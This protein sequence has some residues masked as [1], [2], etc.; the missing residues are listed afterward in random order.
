MAR[1]DRDR[2]PALFT[3]TTSVVSGVILAVLTKA[4]QAGLSAGATVGWSALVSAVVA[5]ACLAG[6]AA[7][8]RTRNRSGTAFLMTS[9][10]TQKYYVSALVQRVHSALDRDDIDLALKVPD[11]DYDAGAQAHHLRRILSKKHSY[12][13]GI[14]IAG[15]VSR[16]REDLTRFCLEFRLP[17]VF[18]DVE[19]FPAESGY[20]NNTAFVG[21]DTGEL[22]ELAGQ[23]LVKHLRGKNRPRVLIIA[24]CEHRGRQQRCEKVLR[25]ALPDVEI[26]VDDQC[27]FMRS[28]AFSVARAQ[29]RRL[30]PH[31][32]LD[33]IFC[34]NDEMALG[35][36]D[37][38]SMSS[39][40]ATAATLVVGVDGVLEAKALIDAGD[41]PLRATV[42]QD[43]HRLAVATVDLL[44]KMHR[45]HPVP[46]RTILNAVLYEAG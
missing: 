9:A 30:E 16:L 28:R 34:T 1:L 2:T 45:G 20:P 25:A 4:L 14:I 10:F 5:L 27:E 24:S 17:V 33:A 18:T 21:Y 36:V 12:L 31:Q 38:L 35:A 29:I 6:F 8:R 42:V 11:R 44:V 7:T 41:S 26:T 15:D 43:T 13:G 37:A 3:V 32:T 46:R 23:W 39:S 22:G 40:P 19:P